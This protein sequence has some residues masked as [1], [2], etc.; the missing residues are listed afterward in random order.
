MHISCY[1]DYLRHLGLHSLRFSFL[2][3]Q[4]SFQPELLLKYG[5]LWRIDSEDKGIN[6][7]PFDLAGV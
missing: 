2:P 5:T 1:F 4:F 7:R 3:F 6:A